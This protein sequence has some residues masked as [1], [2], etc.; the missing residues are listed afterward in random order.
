MKAGKKAIDGCD[1]KM[2]YFFLQIVLSLLPDDHWESHYDLSL[3]LKALM[4]S[5]ANSCCKVD[6][7][8]LILHNIFEKARCLEDK[9]PSY[10]L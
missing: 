4:A 5:T 9:L 10:F 3:R 2:A 7:A 1:H 6:E 8:E